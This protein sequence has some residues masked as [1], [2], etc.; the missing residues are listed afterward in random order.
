MCSIVF[1]RAPRF[2]FDIAFY[3]P[4]YILCIFD[5]SKCNLLPS[6]DYE[7]NRACYFK[8]K[9]KKR[10]RILSMLIYGTTRNMQSNNCEGKEFLMQSHFNHPRMSQYD[11]ESYRL[12][13]CVKIRLGFFR[14][15]VII[16]CY[17]L[18]IIY[19]KRNGHGFLFFSLIFR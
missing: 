5:L 10:S 17:L 14:S 6:I 7:Q 11:L 19:N 9:K 8:K 1:I 3:P 15:L 18:R 16:V 4:T 2:A 12:R 13:V